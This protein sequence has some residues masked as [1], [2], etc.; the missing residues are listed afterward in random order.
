MDF[1]NN[2]YY[3]TRHLMES[4]GLWPYEKPER[5]IVR[6]FCVSFVLTQGILLQVSFDR[7]ICSIILV[8]MIRAVIWAQRP[9]RI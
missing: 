7:C 1:F 9:Q 5:R 4:I 6:G 3:F 2:E 8:R